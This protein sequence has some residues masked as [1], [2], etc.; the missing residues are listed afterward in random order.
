MSLSY[1][2]AKLLFV[3]LVDDGKPRKRNTCDHQIVVFKARHHGHALALAL[4]YGKTQEV[5][6]N[7]LRDQTVRWAFASV[8]TIKKL[9][10]SLA[11]QE[12]GSVLTDETFSQ[13]VPFRK[14]F[15]PEKSE[16]NFE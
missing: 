9:G 3:I 12:I 10:K 1:F 2:S 7:N 16:V 13:P 6:Y 11:G 14:R 5:R 15:H 4:A 8:Q